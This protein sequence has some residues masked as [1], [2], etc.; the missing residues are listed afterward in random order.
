[1]T[2]SPLAAAAAAAPSIRR[3]DRLPALHAPHDRMANAIRALAMDAVE[4][5]KSGH[6]G[7]PMGA[8]D[9]ATVLFTRFL[10]FDPANPQW[11]DR[12]RFVLSAGHGSM[13]IYALLH[14]VGYEKMTIDEIRRF[15]QLGSITPGH[16]EN[17][18]TPGVETTTG[19]LG[20]GLG[21]A[22]GMAIAERHL[23][24][25]FGREIVDHRTY[26]LVSDG[27]LMEGVS[28]EA[29]A[30]AGHLK[31]NRL[32]VLFDDNGISIDGPLSLADSVDQVK[33]FEAAGWAATRIDG[34]DPGAI[35]E[36]I[37]TAQAADRPSLIACR[38]VIGFGAPSKAGTEKC[39]GSP[40]GADE[41]KGAREKLDWSEPAFAVP[42]DVRELWRRAGLAGQP[43]RRAWENRLQAMP[44]ARRAEFER[45]IGGRLPMDDLAA[46]V[47]SVKEK[48]AA[49]PK[50]IA[51]RSASEIAL[52]ALTAAVPEMVGGSADLTG[53]NNTRPKGMTVLSA[54]DYSG[55]FIHYG[56]REHGMAAAMSGMALHGGV[57]PYSGT[58]LVFSDY[59]RPAIRLAALIGLRV[60]YVMTHDSIGLGEDGP[61][62]QPVEHLA[63]LRAIPNLHVFRPCDAVETIECWQLALGNAMGPSV[64]ALTRQSLPQL[65]R[66]LDDAN[67]CAA[68]AYEI[69]PAEDA[70]AVSLFATGSEV[71]IAVA[72]CQ[73]LRER[74]ISSRIVS[75]PCFELFRALPQAERRQIIGA[76]KVNV[77]VEA[78]VRQGWDEIIGADGAFVG[79]SSFGAS[80]PYKELYRHF[81]ITPEHV[82]EAAVG[83]L[84]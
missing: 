84:R 65:R 82:V 13:L 66:A 71:S 55:R 14:L 47:R 22:V 46:A 50:E 40:L 43:V 81:G 52:E 9:V 23:A 57:I 42:A 77:A 67:R 38:T 32:I 59:C 60:V 73:L 45:R 8:A 64:L 83:K 12:D 70:A 44:P 78:A 53:S 76:A 6:P 1:M 20:Q 3:D 41:I 37:E 30:L 36:A 34:H 49:A 58:F 61:T 29:I 21:N 80:A 63:A 18:L 51:T 31:L 56:V 48:L 16:P 17:F 24:A 7:L 28:Q 33:R 2:N 15:R 39:H 5:A 72:A 74:G 10:K 25:T 69:V 54:A 19:P 35:A 68:G 27:D 11:P 26:V 79:M 75:V 4:Q 62:H